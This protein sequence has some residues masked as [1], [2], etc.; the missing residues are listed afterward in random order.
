M[1]WK[2]LGPAVMACSLACPVDRVFAEGVVSSCDEASLRAVLTSGGTVTFACA[3]TIV[4]TNTVEA[5][6]LFDLTV[7]SADSPRFFRV[8]RP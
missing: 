1:L 8:E 6:G 3:G 7:P 4:L 2:S 5:S